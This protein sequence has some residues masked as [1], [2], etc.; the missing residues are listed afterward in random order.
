MW[1]CGVMLDS[2]EEH[3]LCF[4]DFAAYNQRGSFS[5]LREHFIFAPPYFEPSRHPKGF[6]P[7]EDVFRQRLKP[8]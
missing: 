8:T 1:G 3:H 7:K 2:S 4:C 5:A 6:G